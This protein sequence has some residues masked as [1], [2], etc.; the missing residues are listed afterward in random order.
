MKSTG[1]VRRLD[2]LGR[3]VLPMSLRRSFGIEE[4]DGIE[5]FVENDHIILQK[6]KPICVFCGSN[7]EVSDFKNKNVCQECL[8]TM[9]SKA[10]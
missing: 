1:F 9:G 2:S 10:V 3:V 4:K 5:I 7:V 8:T 6:F